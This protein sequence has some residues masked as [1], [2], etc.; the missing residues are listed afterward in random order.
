MLPPADATDDAPVA[1]ADPLELEQTVSDAMA[2]ELGGDVQ[3]D[4]ALGVGD[5][6]HSSF[7]V[8]SD[9]GEG[10]LDAIGEMSF[11]DG[12]DDFMVEPLE[13][14]PIMLDPSDA[15]GMDVAVESLDEILSQSV[16]ETDSESFASSMTYDEMF[17]AASYDEGASAQSAPTDEA[18]ESVERYLA[19]ESAL[20]NDAFVDDALAND[21]L[22]ND[23][24]VNDVLVND[25]L[26][27][28]ALVSD[29]LVSD[30]LV[31]DALVNEQDE[32]AATDRE[33]IVEFQ[34][35][36]AVEEYYPGASAQD[37]EPI[38]AGNSFGEQSVELDPWAGAEL[39]EPA[40]GS[41]GWPSTDADLPVSAPAGEPAVDEVDEMSAALAWSDDAEVA[42]AGDD[43]D[44]VS[45]DGASGV[46]DDDALSAM[47]GELRDSSSAWKSASD[48]IVDERADVAARA[49]FYA[50]PEPIDPAEELAAALEHD[51]YA[52]DLPAANASAGVDVEVGAEA[53]AEL[54]AE[55]TTD[56]AD[57]GDDEHAG[58][59]IADA[60]ARVAA[61]IRAGEVELPSEAA[62][63]SDESALAAALAA[64]LRGPRR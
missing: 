52:M 29:A 5:E 8:S 62:G 55:A 64:L 7:A 20:G 51:A 59:A 38:V 6:L 25:A 33:A 31:S 49:H 45:H 4:G 23:V 46:D 16:A 34:R 2:S 57:A 39:P 11:G 54:R 1:S 42:G 26:V 48:S 24:L 63:A 56:A 10:S 19:E 17:S 22:V 50:A 37:V 61:R 36:S 18:L 60:L 28:D 13:P 44:R 27:S 53:D 40:F 3:G 35:E 43:R 32:V 21:V 41:I 58:A 9:T 30:A 15:G 14:Q 47:V 12:A